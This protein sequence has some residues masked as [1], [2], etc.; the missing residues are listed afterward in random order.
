VGE[1]PRG[2]NYEFGAVVKEEV[3]KQLSEILPHE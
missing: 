1:N 2:E 3:G